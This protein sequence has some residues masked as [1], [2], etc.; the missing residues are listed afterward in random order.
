[1]DLISS[2]GTRLLASRAAFLRVCHQNPAVEKEEKMD[3]F[4]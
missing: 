1:M 4:D 3:R 2:D